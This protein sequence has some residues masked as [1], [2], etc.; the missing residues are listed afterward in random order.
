MILQGGRLLD[1]L[2]TS[3]DAVI[4]MPPVAIMTL[5]LETVRTIP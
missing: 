1:A 3:I 5:V 4:P 2:P